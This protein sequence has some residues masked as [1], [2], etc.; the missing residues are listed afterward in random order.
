V[1]S[2]RAHATDGQLSI[3]PSVLG[4][5]TPAPNQYFQISA[6]ERPD[7]VVR[8][9]IPLVAGG[10]VPGTFTYSFTESFPVVIQ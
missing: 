9:D 1:V 7:Q 2:C 5:I 3:P 4:T 8:A 6:S 10:L